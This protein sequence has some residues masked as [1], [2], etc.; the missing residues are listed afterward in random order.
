ML[1]L[2]LRH[3]R[4]G[5]LILSLALAALVPWLCWPSLGWLAI[6]A[7]PPVLVVT[8]VLLKSYVELIQIVSEMAH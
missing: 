1:R 8:Y 5:A 3:G 2:L 6:L 7:A 4:A